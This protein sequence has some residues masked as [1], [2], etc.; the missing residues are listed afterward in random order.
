MQCPSRLSLHSHRWADVDGVVL[1]GLD[2]IGGNKGGV[3]ARPAMATVHHGSCYLLS[4]ISGPIDDHE[5]FCSA[6]CQPVTQPACPGWYL[7]GFML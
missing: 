7:V 3:C 1:A 6:H 4:R 2:G 5:G